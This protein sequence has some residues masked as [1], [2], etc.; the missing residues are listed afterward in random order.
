MPQVYLSVYRPTCRPV[1][2]RARQ[3]IMS[4]LERE[5]GRNLGLYVLAYVNHECLSVTW[6]FLTKISWKN[7]IFKTWSRKNNHNML[8]FLLQIFTC[9]YFCCPICRWKEVFYRKRM[10]YYFPIYIC[11]YLVKLL[12]LKHSPCFATC[13]E[14]K[15]G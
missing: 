6:V 8:V 10:S 5:M 1:V 3:Y 4:V 12:P 15:N 13:R 14:D 11:L 7:R 2:L 9:N